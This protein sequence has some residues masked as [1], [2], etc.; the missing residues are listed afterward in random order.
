MVKQFKGAWRNIVSD[1][2]SVVL[3]RRDQ[4][5][6]N[7]EQRSSLG[8]PDSPDGQQESFK[9]IHTSVLHTGTLFYNR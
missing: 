1:R 9:G 3:S 6:Q 8:T 5:R 7:S 4:G 2:V